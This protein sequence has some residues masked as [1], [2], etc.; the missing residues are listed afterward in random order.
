[1]KGE[2]PSFIQTSLKAPTKHNQIAL[3][4]QSPARGQRR[5]T[6]LQHSAQRSAGCSSWQPSA[7]AHLGSGAAAQCAAEA[8]ARPNKKIVHK[9]GVIHS[10]LLP[11]CA[12]GRRYKAD[13]A[14]LWRQHTCSPP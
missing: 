1:M 12:V 6:R 14:S 10:H 8:Q 4:K 3:Y 5:G 2:D 9:A 7:A 11:H 13:H